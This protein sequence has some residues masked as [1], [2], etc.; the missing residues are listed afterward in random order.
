[1]RPG[2]ARQRPPPGTASAVRNLL[3]AMDCRRARCFIITS[4]TSAQQTP[5]CRKNDFRLR[6]ARSFN[7]FLERLIECLVRC[8]RYSSR[9]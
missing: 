8:A 3:A 6:T 9:N 7:P 1:M 4:M 5:E 2:Q